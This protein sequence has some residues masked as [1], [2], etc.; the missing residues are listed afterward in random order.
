MKDYLDHTFNPDDPELISIQ[1]ELPFW[2]APF[3]FSLLNTIRMK[4]NINELDI[5]SGF[6]FP[7]LEVS[8]RLG[9]TCNV[10]G[11]DPWKPAIERAE[12]KIKMYN[13]S[14]VKIIDC[15]AEKL[16]FEDSF[17]DLIISNNGI[18]NVKDIPAVF[19]ECSRV[20]KNGAQFVFTF[21]LDKTM[22]E[23]YDIYEKVLKENLWI[24]QK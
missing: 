1:D 6:G 17:F 5:G 9:K 2:S 12:K 18:N 3:G 13:L 22:I 21:N 11:V 7:L 15:C 10:F 14:N 23:F 24:F 8:Q 16:P 20:C 19:N 4:K